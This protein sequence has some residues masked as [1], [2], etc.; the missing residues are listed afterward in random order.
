MLPV[1]AWRVWYADGSSFSSDDGTWADAP[2]FGL[3]CVVWYHDPPFR[4]VDTG[5]TDGV[6]CW[7]SDEFAGTDVK[8]GL[9]VDADTHYRVMDM[10][11]RATMPGGCG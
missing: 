2:A 7:Q 1:K 9:W 6:V 11:R 10:A 4:T 3:Q 5:G 8:L